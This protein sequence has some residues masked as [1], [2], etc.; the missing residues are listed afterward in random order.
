VQLDVREPLV[1]DLVLS[2]LAC[3]AMANDDTKVVRLENTLTTVVA[4][5]NFGVEN[6]AQWISI[7]EETTG[8]V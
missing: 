7:E 5:C 6:K 3:N 2:L 4:M 8:D 1:A